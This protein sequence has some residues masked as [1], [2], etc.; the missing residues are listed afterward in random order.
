[1][2]LFIVGELSADRS[3]IILM[4]AGSDVEV[5]AASRLMATTTPLTRNSKPAGGLVVPLSW[6]A[7]VQF[8]SMFGHAWKPQARLATWI[9]D[10]ITARTSSSAPDPAL[11]NLP[12]GLVPRSYQIS[13]AAMIADQGGALL[14]DEMGTGKTPSAILGISELARRGKKPFPCIVV[15]PA[16]VADSW[17]DHFRRWSPGIRVVAW[18]GT[19]AVRRGLIGTSDVYVTSYDTCRNDASKAA[20]KDA[21]LMALKARTIISDEM[22]RLKSRSSKQSQAV[23]RLAKKCAFFVGLSGTPIT[24]HPGNL[25]PALTCLDS[26]AWPSYERWANRYLRTIPGD[27]GVTVLGLHPHF[28][29]EFRLGLL[30]QTRRV[31]KADVLTELPPK[32]YSVRTVALPPEWRQAYDAMESDML[33]SLPDGEEL[34]VMG[35][36]AQLTRLSQLACAPAD[37]ETTVEVVTTAGLDEE[38]V[39]TKVSLKAPS[40]KVDALLDVLEERCDPEGGGSA[41]DGEQVVCFAPS[42]QLMT[43]AGEAAAGAGYRVGYIVGGQSMAERTEVIRRF[44]IGGGAEL[45]L[46]CVTTAAGGEGITLTAARTCVFLQRPWSM[47][48]AV[49]CEDRLHRI[50]AE[51]H[52]SIEVIDVV[53][54]NTIDTRVRAVIREK[55][56]QFSDLVQDPRIVAGLL[57]GAGVARQRV[58]GAGRGERHLRAVV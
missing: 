1:M 3:H 57:G 37:V 40:W 50:G 4:A 34:S 52:D 48:E 47:G 51:V 55:G 46:L 28:E 6:S 32:I 15:C 44:Q 26:D 12:E 54:A 9:A 49:Q 25:W 13:A 35:V 31:A 23:R 30:G 56:K 7:T 22:H 39:H 33:A 43:L 58:A 11:W 8:A 24:H 10:Q 17:V 42:R 5:A 27:Y 20:V 38:I 21:P 14:L 53:A 18:R 19:P 2:P 41:G 16:S 45:D 29:P 36:L